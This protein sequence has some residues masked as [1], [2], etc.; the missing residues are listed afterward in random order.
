MWYWL[1]V[2]EL[3]YQLICLTVSDKLLFYARQ[4]K[5]VFYCVLVQFQI[6]SSY[7]NSSFYTWQLAVWGLSSH[8]LTWFFWKFVCFLLY[9]LRSHITWVSWLFFFFN[10][11]PSVWDT[12]WG[13]AT[14]DVCWWIHKGMKGVSCCYHVVIVFL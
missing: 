10:S 14:V 9:C 6:R 1:R 7:L 12:I 3:F 13:R 5:I 4:H 11:T 8:N 2:K